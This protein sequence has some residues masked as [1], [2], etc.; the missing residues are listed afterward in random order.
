[1]LLQHERTPA[2]EPGSGRN[3]PP[4]APASL[5]VGRN[6]TRARSLPTAAPDGPQTTVATTS[7]RADGE[8]GDGRHHLLQPPRTMTTWDVLVGRKPAAREPPANVGTC[9]A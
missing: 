3:Q 1:M 8:P 4:A 6:P 2:G 7:T 5:P 9:P